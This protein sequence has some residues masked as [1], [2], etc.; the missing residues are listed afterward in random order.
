VTGRIVRMEHRLRPR[1]T[2]VVSLAFDKVEVEGKY[3]RLRIKSEGNRAAT[4]PEW[5][6]GAFSFPAG[7]SRYVIPAGFK[8][9]WLTVPQAQPVEAPPHSR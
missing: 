8:S 7:N 6:M 5:P 2:F 1:N 9:K 4:I 3:F